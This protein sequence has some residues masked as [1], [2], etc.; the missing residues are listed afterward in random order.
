MSSFCLFPSIFCVIG[1][2]FT[3]DRTLGNCSASSIQLGDFGTTQDMN[4]FMKNGAYVIKMKG[5]LDIFSMNESYRWAGQV[6][7]FYLH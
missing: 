3:I 1:I 2:S 4:A 6:C 7:I 5:P